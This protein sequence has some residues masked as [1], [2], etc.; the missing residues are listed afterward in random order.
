MAGTAAYLAFAERQGK[1][2][3]TAANLQTT[4]ARIAAEQQDI[5][6]FAGQLLVLLMQTQD[7]RKFAPS[8]ECH[9]FLAKVLEQEP[10][11]ANIA[12]AAP[13]GDLICN[14][15]APPHPVNVADRVHFLKASNTS[16]LVVGE[17]VVSRST[18]KW[19]LP[20]AKAIRDDAG[21]LQGVLL[22]LIDLAWVNRRLAPE[23]Y[24]NATRIG[25]IDDRG[26]VLARNPD[27]EQWIGR[28]AADSP[29]FKTLIAHGGTGTAEAIGF[30]GVARLYAL[31]HFTE[32]DVGPIYLWVGI[33][34]A[35]IENSNRTFLWTL[36][37]MLGLLMISFAAIWS[38]S[39]RLVLRPVS[40]LAATIRN[41]AGGDYNA[42]TGLPHGND[43]LGQLAHSLDGMAMAL[44]SKSEILRLNRA[45][46]VL[47]AC[48]RM[49]IH[50]DSEAQLLNDICRLLVELGNYRFA[51]VG[52]NLHDA[53]KSVS[54]VAHCGYQAGYLDQIRI[55]W[56]DTEQ[57]RGPTGTAIRTG[58]TQVNQNFATNPA[59]APWRADA[60]RRGYQSSIALPLTLKDSAGCF[61]AL[62]IYAAEHDAFNADEVK[63]LEELADDV[64]FGINT[65]RLR[66]S[67]NATTVRL[68]RSMEATIAAMA[69]TLEMRDPYTAGH[70]RRVAEL[71]VMIAK[72]LALPDDE[73]HGIRLAGMVHDLGKIQIPAEILAKPTRL[74]DIEYRLIKNHVIAGYE[75]LKGIDFPW[76]LAELV[77]QHHERLDGSGYP[78]GLKSEEI[79]LGAKI[80]AVADTLEAMASHRPYRPALGIKAALEEIRKNR[81]KL[82]DP[83]IVDACEKLFGDKDFQFP[84]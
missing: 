72:Q 47:S 18:G 42:R 19:S 7:L 38:G 13:N 52:L 45:L 65:L 61:G 21:E 30:D 55:R 14:A 44:A 73:I 11:V 27:P 75:I 15:A 66:A 5:V 80:L 25:L 43:E 23:K 67:H 54:P 6:T 50:A 33:S 24:P 12:I 60:L 74:S 22:V 46:R 9:E 10:R 39:D 71:A 40:R 4:V 34:K 68:E 77:V 8:R 57:G 20:F 64:A 63:L 37:V 84:V 83:A 1:L 53:D 69:T 2:A 16:N 35:V 3:A 76:P 70:Q 59:T 81:G 26:T 78:R 51:W 28:N 58:K 32:T 29:F 82:Y 79:L 56:S 17:A 48:N 36:S 49:L 41:L 62:T 31:A